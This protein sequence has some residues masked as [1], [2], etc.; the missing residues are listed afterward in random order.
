MEE[1]KKKVYISVPIS[2]RDMKDVEADVERLRGIIEEWGMEA[3]SPLE[4]S[5]GG[6]D[7]SYAEHM[8][9]DIT[10]LMGCDAALFAKGWEMSKGCAL[11]LYVAVHYGILDL[12]E[13]HVTKDQ[14]KEILEA[15]N[16][17][18]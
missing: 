18:L 17:R 5:P 10:A 13:C 11:E 8:G 12:F 7:V 3:V 9:R 15:L 6:D 2:G 14:G 4:V 16:R 1:K